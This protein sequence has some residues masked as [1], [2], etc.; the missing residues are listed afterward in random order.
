MS[1]NANSP[2]PRPSPASGRGGEFKGF[3]DYVEVFRSG[4]HT[5]SSGNRQEWTDAHLDQIVANFDAN[6]SAPVV[7]GHPKTDSPAWGWVESLKRDGSGLFVKFHKLTPK[8]IEWAKGGHVRNRS[9]KIL[10]TPK[11]YKLGHVG[12]L[13]AAPP[14][15]EGLAPLQFDASQ[16]G[17]VF[18]F[19]VPAGFQMSLLA[20]SLRRMRDFFIEKFGAETADR[21]M[22]AWDIEHAEQL[23]AEASAESRASSSFNAPAN[24]PVIPEGHPMTGNAATFTQADLDAAAEKARKE[25]EDATTAKLAPQL[26]AAE[27]AKRLAANKAFVAGLVKDPDGKCRLT[28]AQAA[29]VAEFLS[30]LEG[31]EA[32]T[33]EFTFTADKDEQKKAT[34]A[35]FAKDLLGGLPVQ[36]QLGQERATHDAPAGATSHFNAPAG[37]TV[38][39]DRAAL[40]TKAKA[41]QAEHPSTEWLDC[42]KAVGG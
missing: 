27:F 36:L 12:F 42:V 13:G 26:Q 7:I 9:V 20:R 35:Q 29:G 33:A 34:L 11:G 25:A 41:Y 6:D 24:P 10:S 14:A 2:S 28:P 3:D 5:D 19:A 18:E 21:V 31:F 17:Q 32:T 1:T 40:F 15:I 30:A 39:N 38:S 37:T 4:T 23:A 8:F 16:P 22:P